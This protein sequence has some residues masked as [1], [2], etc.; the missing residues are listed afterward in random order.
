[1]ISPTKVRAVGLLLLAFVVGGVAGAAVDRAWLRPPL[2]ERRPP[3]RR[4][5]GGRTEAV[6]ADRIPTPLEALQL[7][8]DEERR[9]HE[10]ARRWRPRAAEAVNQMRTTV[11]DL[12]N[13]M[14]AE[15]LCVISREKQERYL[16]QLQEN[17]APPSMIDKRFRLVRANQC[18]QVRR[19]ESAGESKR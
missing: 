13:D 2:E 11:S 3:G 10:I 6:E 5:P 15:M 19:G 16:A 18:E 4:E 8:P 14:F 12:E 17:G 1:M 9:L 7:S